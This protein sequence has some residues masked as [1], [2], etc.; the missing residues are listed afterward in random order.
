[1]VKF[2]FETFRYSR[3]QGRGFLK[4]HVSQNFIGGFAGKVNPKVM[5]KQFLGEFSVSSNE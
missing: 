5:L 1:V 2:L 4:P 3:R